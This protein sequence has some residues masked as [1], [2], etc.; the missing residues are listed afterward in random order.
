MSRVYCRENFALAIPELPT[1]HAYPPDP[2]VHTHLLQWSPDSGWSFN[3]S[4]TGN[5]K[6][7]WEATQFSSLF[8]VM[9]SAT[10]TKFIVTNNDVSWLTSIHLIFISWDKAGIAI[11]MLE[12]P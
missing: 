10:K 8:T 5:N 9:F 2:G 11:S 7:D 3:L 4:T 1:A 6:A 12:I